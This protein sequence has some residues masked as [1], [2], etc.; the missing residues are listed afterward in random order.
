MS[1]KEISLYIHIPFCVSKCDYCDF[2]SV[3]TGCKKSA[4]QD[5]YINALCNEI[6]FRFSNYQQSKIKTVYIG[7]GTPSLLNEN[8][9]KTISDVIKQTGL[10]QDYE[11]TFEVNPDDVTEQL[12]L[13]LDS[14]GINRISCGIQSFD[15]D[16]LKK[17]KRRADSKTVLKALE[18]LKSKWNKRLSVDLICG[19]PGETQKSMMKGLE[20]LVQKKIEHISFYSLCV[21]EETPLGKS[22]TLGDTPYDYDFCD[23]LW[24]KGRDYL[25]S[26]GYEQYEVSNFCLPQN[27]CLHNMTYWTHK[28]YIGC[29]SGGTGTIYTAKGEG[30]RYTNDKNISEYIDFWTKN[31]LENTQKVSNIPQSVE[32]IIQKTSKFEY[33]M[34]ALRTRRGVSPAEYQEIFGE[35][36]SPVIQKKL[37]ST[38]KESDSGN[39]YLEKDRLLFLNTF[40]EELLDLPD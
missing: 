8:Q 37:E 29:G 25:I 38:C 3:P 21:E 28:D 36:I 27:E 24:L 32:K 17:V 13:A 12:L 23:E 18:L 31:N 39:Y 9:I 35:P 40:L 7:G 2:F 33:F 30:T 5:E 16:V 22:I 34:M 1:C 4:V 10:T 20:L 15:D 19:L 14:C 6:K 11:F 26:N